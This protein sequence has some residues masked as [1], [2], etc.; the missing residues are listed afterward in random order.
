MKITH[1]FKAIYFAKINGKIMGKNNILQLSFSSYL[2]L[3][4]ATLLILRKKY[5][6]QITRNG[7]KRQRH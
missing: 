1:L 6:G 2:R 3:R 5:I 4:L 7:V